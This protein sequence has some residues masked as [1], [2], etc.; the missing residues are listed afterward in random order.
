V[1]E[2]FEQARRKSDFAFSLQ[3]Q[4]QASAG[5][6]L[7]VAVGLPPLPPVAKYPRNFRPALSP[8]HGDC[9]ADFGQIILIEKATPNSVGRC[10]R[11]HEGTI[12]DVGSW[13]L[14]NF[15]LVIAYPGTNA[16]YFRQPHGGCLLYEK[17]VHQRQQTQ[18][19]GFVA[20]LSIIPG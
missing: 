20:F 11:V 2:G 3:G 15:Y 7:D 12:A 5:L 13:R 6:I 19:V 4:Q 18:S 10:R 9:L 16:V 14:Q 17:N 1:S 8:V